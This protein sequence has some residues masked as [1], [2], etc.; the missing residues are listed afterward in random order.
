MF[1]LNDSL[2]DTN[3]AG[4]GRAAL[5]SKSAAKGKYVVELKIIHMAG[6]VFIGAMQATRKVWV[7]A[8]KTVSPIPPLV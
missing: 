8:Q 1:L 4:R 3:L 7:R 6:T 2:I 5:L